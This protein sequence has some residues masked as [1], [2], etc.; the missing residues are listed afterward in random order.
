MGT[1]RSKCLGLIGFE[2]VLECPTG[3]GRYVATISNRQMVFGAPC[4]HPEF[5]GDSSGCPQIGPAL[6]CGKQKLHIQYGLGNIIVETGSEV[7][8]A[9]TNH[10]MRG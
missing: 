9:V 7:L 4:E 6:D 5:P 8:L 1:G 10:R 2:G 3:K